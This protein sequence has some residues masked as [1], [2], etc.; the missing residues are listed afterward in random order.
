MTASH[1]VLM[2]LK[3]NEGFL[4]GERVS[5]WS[6]GKIDVD[7][8]LCSQSYFKVEVNQRLGIS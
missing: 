3:K 6:T 1:V 2:L 7:R 8:N 5:Q 4:E